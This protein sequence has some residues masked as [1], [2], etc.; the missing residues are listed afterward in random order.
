MSIQSKIFLNR[1]YEEACDVLA[2]VY[3]TTVSSNYTERLESTH[4]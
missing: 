1:I 3:N 2:N 4:N